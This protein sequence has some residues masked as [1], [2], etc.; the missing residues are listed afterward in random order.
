MFLLAHGMVKLLIVRIEICRGKDMTGKEF[1]K[2][3]HD[4]KENILASYFAEDRESEVAS[5]LKSLIQAGVSKDEL[6]RLVDTVMTDSYYT[7]LLG[8]DGAGSLGNTQKTYKLLDEN[9]ELLNPC[10]ELEEN[11]YSYFIEE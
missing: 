6:Y 2:L 8:I 1:V 9:G 4:E 7:L 10:G 5:I 11:A 3:C